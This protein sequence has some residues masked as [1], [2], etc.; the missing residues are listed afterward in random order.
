MP[1]ASHSDFETFDIVRLKSQ[2]TAAFE[3]LVRAS[4]GRMLA[5]ASRMLHC[6]QDAQDAVQDAFIQA[7]KALPQ[8]E[9]RCSVTTWMHS[10]TVRACLMKLRRQRSRKE[11]DIEP[12]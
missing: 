5:V 4:T 7:Y 9:A 6:D 8:F 2:D 3:S 11:T 10:I 1:V 12:L